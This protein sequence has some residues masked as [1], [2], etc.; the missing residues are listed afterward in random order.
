MEFSRSIDEVIADYLFEGFK[1]YIKGF[2][3]IPGVPF[4][5]VKE[6]NRAL[7][8]SPNHFKMYFKEGKENGFE[9]DLEKVYRPRTPKTISITFKNSTKK[10]KIEFV[11]EEK[12]IVEL[13]QNFFHKYSELIHK[14][15]DEVGKSKKKRNQLVLNVFYQMRDLIESYIL[16]KSSRFGREYRKEKE[17]DGTIHYFINVPYNDEEKIEI[18]V[19]TTELS[20]DVSFKEKDDLKVISF[21]K[22]TTINNVV[23]DL[24]E[25]L[26]K[27]IY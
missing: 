19:Y 4:A 20:L 11:Y 26:S 1:E 9:V 25:T 6:G 14:Y 21:D 23:N 10:D 17:V 8:L 16:D 12:D 22:Y 7:E 24:E 2:P 27:Y 3:N 13:Y 15:G 18:I 5:E